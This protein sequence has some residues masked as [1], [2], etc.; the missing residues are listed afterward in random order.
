M[1]VLFS[2]FYVSCGYYT[3]DEPRIQELCPSPNQAVG[4]HV[5]VQSAILSIIC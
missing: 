3:G 5:N 4:S 1:D 2:L